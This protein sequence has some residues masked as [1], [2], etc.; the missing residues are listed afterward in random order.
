MNMAI[1][2]AGI[3][4]WDAKYFY[5]YPRPI[6]AIPG[7]KTILGTPNFPSYTSGHATFSSAAAEVL[8]HIFPA[9]AAT[10]FAW[11]D[12]AAISRAYAGIR[13]T[14]DTEAGNLQGT[15]VAEYAIQVLSE[16]GGE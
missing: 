14:F 8:A 5:H 10:A 7:F 12:E 6:Q 4:C 16:D 13:Y 2:D 11:S 15:Q 9:E 1:Q 3:A